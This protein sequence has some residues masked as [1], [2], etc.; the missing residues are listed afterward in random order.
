MLTV[1]QNKRFVETT[2]GWVSIP[3]ED[4]PVRVTD[5][6]GVSKDA[7]VQRMQA[8][9]DNAEV[10]SFEDWLRRQLAERDSSD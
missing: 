8:R 1:L 7:T 6:F 4:E 10:E 9:L 5:A 2:P 3:W